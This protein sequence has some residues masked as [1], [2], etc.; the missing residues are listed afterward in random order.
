M[1]I[2]YYTA[3]IVAFT[4]FFGIAVFAMFLREHRNCKDFYR[5]ADEHERDFHAHN[6]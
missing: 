4:L 6:H 2:H 1:M 3:F 5:K